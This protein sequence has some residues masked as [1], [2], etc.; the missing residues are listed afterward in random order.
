[1]FKE[2]AGNVSAYKTY[3][4]FYFKNFPCSVGL[5]VGLK[6]FGITMFDGCRTGKGQYNLMCRKT[7]SSY[8]CAAR[9][10]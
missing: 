9:F 4:T 6:M 8:S 5:Y 2:D 7:K 3:I 1:L 10:K